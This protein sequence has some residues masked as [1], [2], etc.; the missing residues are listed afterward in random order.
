MPAPSRFGSFAPAPEALARAAAIAVKDSLKVQSGEKVIII[1]NPVKDVLEISQAIFDAV[2]EVGG[3]PSIIIQ[4]VKKQTDSAEDCVISAFESQPDVLISLSANKMG[5]DKEGIR[6]PYEWDGAYYDHVFH[7]QLYGAKTL[8]AF[9][10]PS[11]NRGIF[12]TTVP[13]DYPLLKKRCQKI[14]D[15]LDQALRIRVTN[16]LGTDIEVGVQG[17]NAMSDDG[18]FS[19]PGKGGNLPAGEVFISPVVGDSEG[20]IVFDGSISINEGDI[21]IKTPIKAVISKGFVTQISGGD[22]AASLLRTIEGAESQARRME[23]EDAL[24]AGKGEIY[25]KNARNL[26]ELGIGLNPQAGIIGNML[27]DEKAFGTCHFAIGHN[28]DS[29]APALIH[30]D[31]L[32]SKPTITAI[33][34]GGKEVLIEAEGILKL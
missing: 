26:G 19:R 8:R 25:A 7:Y 14:K 22:E 20:T 17:R 24:P 15:V 32:V 5:K 2:C 1:T 18:D 6:V 3:H 30:L 29:D 34:A 23:A 11:V 31:G 16:A 33:L 13:I 10:S 21:V 12:E 28:Y 4:T 9:W 27:Q